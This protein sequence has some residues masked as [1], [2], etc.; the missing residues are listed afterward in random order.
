[1][2]RVLVTTPV[3]R[4]R[5]KL[6]S[7]VSIRT[8]FLNFGPPAGR[9]NCRRSAKSNEDVF[10]TANYGLVD[11]GVSLAEDIISCANHAD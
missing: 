2:N 8:T 7:G 3:R 10:E 9:S 6:R 4:G 11:L 1:M 5:M